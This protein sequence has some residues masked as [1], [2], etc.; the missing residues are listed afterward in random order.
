LL[1]I[2]KQTFAIQGMTKWIT[3]DE[4][5]NVNT[6]HLANHASGSG[7]VNAVEIRESGTLMVS[8]DKIFEMLVKTGHRK[9]NNKI[10][11][12]SKSCYKYHKK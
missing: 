12:M 2:Q 6:N 4:T 7:I 11:L 3:F 8:M 5:P 10:G 1:C 9:G